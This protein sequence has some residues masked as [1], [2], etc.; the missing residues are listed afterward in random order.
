MQKSRKPRILIWDIETSPNL[1]YVWGK[2]EQNVI[3]F[4]KEWELLSVAYKW[5]GESQVYCVG[6]CDFKDS[7][8]RALVDKVWQLLDE[9]D[10][11]IAH[12]G[13]QF[14]NKKIRAKFVEHGFKPPKPY[15]TIDTKK[16]AKNNFNFNSNSL[17]DLGQLLKLGKKVETGGF[18][19][20]LKCMAG[21]DKAW[22]K[23]KSYNKQDVVLLEKVYN[24]LKIW[25]EKHINL[26][27]LE[28][29]RDAC[30]ICASAK[31]QKRGFYYARTTKRVRWSCMECGHWFSGTQ[32]KL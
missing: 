1:A 17:N 32:S 15:K 10:V 12:N 24:K 7:T 2:W 30:P 8:D 11:A 20:W 21:D 4:K 25:D 27:A 28:D 16:I 26:A 6:R 22:K 29:K 14:D 18:D 19:L 5:L 23:M 9:S 3:S 13:D 31:V